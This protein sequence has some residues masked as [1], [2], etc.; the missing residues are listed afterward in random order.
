MTS[1]YLDHSRL[2]DVH[3]WSD[4]PETDE[5]R[6]MRDQFTPEPDFQYHDCNISRVLVTL[7]NRL[8]GSG[9]LDSAPAYFD[10]TAGE[11]R[12]SRIRPTQ[13]LID[14]SLDLQPFEQM[15]FH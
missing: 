12:E 2:F 4:Y 13:R 15:L 6:A 7:I 9:L 1:R 3:R 8:V 11:G 14:M 10:R 5:T